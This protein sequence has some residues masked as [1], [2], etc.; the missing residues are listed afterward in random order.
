MLKR[1][2]RALRPS[3]PPLRMLSSTRFLAVRVRRERSRKRMHR[4]TRDMDYHVYRGARNDH[5]GS[6]LRAILKRIRIRLMIIAIYTGLVLVGI[7]VLLLIFAVI[8]IFSDGGFYEACDEL[9]SAPKPNRC[10]DISMP[11]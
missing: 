8:S 9:W 3:T 6:T 11:G 4:V 1:C 5:E 2:M 7:L 10:P